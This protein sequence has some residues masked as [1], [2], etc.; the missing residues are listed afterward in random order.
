M[1]LHIGLHGDQARID[2][3]PLHESPA[4]SHEP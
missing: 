4:P 3:A 1:R 2:G